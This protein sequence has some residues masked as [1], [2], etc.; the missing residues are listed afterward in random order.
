[1][2][3]VTHRGHDNDGGEGDEETEALE[4]LRDLE[5]LKEFI[6]EMEAETNQRGTWAR[7]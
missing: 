1:M 7:M 3:L 5:E 4:E 6:R 2:P